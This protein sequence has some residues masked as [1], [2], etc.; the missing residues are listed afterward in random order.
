MSAP[1]P[2][3]QIQQL[4]QDLRNPSA[5]RREATAKQLSSAGTVDPRVLNALWNLASSDPVLY[6]RQASRDTLAAL[7]KTPPTA[8]QEQPL[9]QKGSGTN[10][11]L[12]IGAIVVL[13]CAVPVCVI[14][15][16]AILGPQIGNIFSRVTNGLAG[17]P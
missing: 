15:I 14:S 2:E 16:L 13:V 1:N 7:G 4:L 17:S 11:A 9:P 6:V 10:W 12:I 8:A 5:K 3:P